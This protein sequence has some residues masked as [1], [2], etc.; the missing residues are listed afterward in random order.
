MRWS[1]LTD[2]SPYSSLAGLSLPGGVITGI[3]GRSTCHWPGQAGVPASPG[4]EPDNGHV[5]NISPAVLFLAG[6]SLQVRGPSR[7]CLLPC[8]PYGEE[9]GAMI[10]GNSSQTRPVGPPS[11]PAGS[12]DR[13]PGILPTM[14]DHLATALKNEKD[15]T[16]P[17]S[18]GVGTPAPISP[19]RAGA[20]K[21]RQ[22]SQ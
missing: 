7:T 2:P 20:G 10:A 13:W 14:P 18:A 4:R 8:F 6:E 21:R 15:L 9:R 12:F 1:G 19:R 22:D 16:P 17:G 11:P 3:S 5:R